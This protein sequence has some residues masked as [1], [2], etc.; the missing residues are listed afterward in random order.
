MSGHYYEKKAYNY[1]CVDKEP[2]AIVGRDPD[3]HAA[4][5]CFVQIYCHFTGHCPPYINGAELNCVVCSK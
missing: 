1:E 3:E 5:F 4:L 2:E